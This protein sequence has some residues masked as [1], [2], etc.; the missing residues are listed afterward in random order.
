MVKLVDMAKT[1]A[2][3]HKDTMPCAPGSLSKYDYGLSICLNQESL[4]KLGAD[5]DGIE[6]GDMVE[7]RALAK[8]TSI[9]KN[10]TGDG[11]KSRVELT[12]CYLGAELEDAEADGG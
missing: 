5:V 3:M 11:E 9:S 10:D 12:I 1:D 8:V 4:D 7:L 2:E 6:V